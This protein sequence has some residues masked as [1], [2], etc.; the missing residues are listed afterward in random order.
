MLGC[1]A[2][3]EHFLPMVEMIG[4]YVV[5]IELESGF[6]LLQKPMESSKFT[7]L[8]LFWKIIFGEI[9]PEVIFGTTNRLLWM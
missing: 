4:I 3:V 7:D 2:Y 9:V 5:N 1:K 6:A 8:I